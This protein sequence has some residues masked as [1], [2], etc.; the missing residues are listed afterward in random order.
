MDGGS[1]E[2]HG[3]CSEGPRGPRHGG[4][5]RT[6]AWTGRMDRRPEGPRGTLA[7]AGR[8]DAARE[9]ARG[10]R[11]GGLTPPYSRA[12]CATHSGPR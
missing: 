3:R 6:V 4:A 11:P 12:P 7:R 5:A 10:H 1:E 8:T 9:A 2:P